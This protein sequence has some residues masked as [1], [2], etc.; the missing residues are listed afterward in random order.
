M[1]K[2]ICNE[3]PRATSEPSREIPILVP[4]INL[5][6]L[7]GLRVGAR[8]GGPSLQIILAIYKVL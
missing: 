4:K 6:S 3:G 1:A 7:L 2:I 5:G 8:L